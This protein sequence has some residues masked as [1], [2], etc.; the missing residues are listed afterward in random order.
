MEAAGDKG[1]KEIEGKHERLVG[2]ARLDGRGRPKRSPRWA[3]TQAWEMIETS[4]PHPSS[5]RRRSVQVGK[6]PQA[7]RPIPG[8][9][10]AGHRGRR[11]RNCCRSRTRAG[12]DGPMA[13]A[14]IASFRRLMAPS[15]AGGAVSSSARPGRSASGARSPPSRPRIPHRP[16]GAFTA[17]ERGVGLPGIPE[18]RDAA[19][20][21]EANGAGGVGHAPWDPRPV[22]VGSLGRVAVLA[23][24]GGQGSHAAEGA[25]RL[26][27][28]GDLDAEIPSP[29]CTTSSR[30]SIESSD[31]PPP[32]RGSS[33]GMS[34]SGDILQAQGL[35]NQLL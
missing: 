32:T 15:Q 4:G 10:A 33:S 6:A 16:Q 18:R 22:Q 11:P 7:A 12:R 13:P 28:T 2:Q 34:A 17:Q 5:A 8:P 21:G 19:A 35:H 1:A 24:I 9:C 26:L 23:D 20:G 27:A 3:E 31:S 30:A 14:G 25:P 29:A